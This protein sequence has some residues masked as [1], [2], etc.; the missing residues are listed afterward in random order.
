MNSFGYGDGVAQ[1]H[2]ASQARA[3]EGPIL[4]RGAHHGRFGFDDTVRRPARGAAEISWKIGHVAPVD[5][6]LH[7]HLLEAA[8]AVAKRSDG[9]M[10]ITVVGE[11]RLG[12]QSGLLGQVRNGGLEMTAATCTQMEPTAPLC[13]IPSIGFLFASY[14]SVWPAIDAVLGQKITSRSV[15]TQYRSLGEDMGLWISPYH[16][17]AA[18]HSNRGGSVGAP[19]QDTNQCRP[20]G[21]VSIP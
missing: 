6:P 3:N 14:A 2:Q 19:D 18:P 9:M 16:D 12:I 4:S 13:A 20:D 8:D 11:G 1:R 5:T 21:Y 15:P 7:R 10:Q 17:L